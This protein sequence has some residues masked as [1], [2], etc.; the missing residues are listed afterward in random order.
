MLNDLDEMES[1]ISSTLKFARDDAANELIEPLDFAQLVKN[2]TENLDVT[3]RLPD[4]LAFV[5]RPLGLKRLVGNLVGNAQ[6]FGTKVEIEL[7]EK[8]GCLELV[9]LDDGPGIPDD[10]IERVFDPFVRVENSRS[11]D[12]GG[13]GLGLVAV[14]MVAQAHGGTVELSNRKNGGLRATVRLPLS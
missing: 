13:T 2:L 8:D 14:K 10:M 9:V 1:M 7:S 5:G 4:T 6:G 11:R 3:C 12:T